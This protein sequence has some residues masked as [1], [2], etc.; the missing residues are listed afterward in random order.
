MNKFLRFSEKSQT[1][2]LILVLTAF[3][4]SSGKASASNYCYVAKAAEST[5][6]ANTSRPG[7]DSGPTLTPISTTS[8]SIDS[9]SHFFSPSIFPTSGP[10]STAADCAKA[11]IRFGVLLG[12]AGSSNAIYCQFSSSDNN[13]PPKTA[14]G[15]G[16]VINEKWFNITLPTL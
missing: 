5:V 16:T 10:A 7:F 6:S 9:N 15:K 2:S 3:L 1:F 13:I 8:T 11:C 12:T 4:F 14:Y